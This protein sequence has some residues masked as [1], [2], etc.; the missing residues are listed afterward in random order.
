MK[1]YRSCRSPVLLQKSE[2]SLTAN[3]ETLQRTRHIISFIV[4]YSNNNSFK[5]IIKKKRIYVIYN[6]RKITFI[7][8][9]QLYNELNK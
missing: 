8:M 7:I 9:L 6:H 5:D 4:A 1:L 2:Y 3:N